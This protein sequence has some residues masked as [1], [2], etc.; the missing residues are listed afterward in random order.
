MVGVLWIRSRS[1]SACP[2]WWWLV[3]F[4]EAL[5]LFPNIEREG[6]PQRR[7]LK[8]DSQYKL[9]LTKGGL[10]LP[11]VLAMTPSWVHGDLRLAV[12]LVLVS[13]HRYGNLYLMPRDSLPALAPLAPKRKLVLC[14]HWRP[15]SFG[16][17]GS[18]HVNLARCPS[19]LIT[20]LLASQ[21]SEAALE[22]VLCRPPREAWPLARF[23]SG[24]R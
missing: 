8:G 21:P 23:L 24:C 13:L 9:I 15:P 1:E 12:L 3:L 18:R 16:R 14:A 17:H 7:D 20:P 22:E 11:K 10:R 5:V 6:I 19:A 2:L 4:I